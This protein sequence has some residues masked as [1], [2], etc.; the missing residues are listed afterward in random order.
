M[1]IGGIK[2][3]KMFRIAKQQSLMSLMKFLQSLKEITMPLPIVDTMVNLMRS[4]K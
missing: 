2:H 4:G 1:I 3:Y